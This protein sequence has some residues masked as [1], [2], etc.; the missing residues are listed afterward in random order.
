MT[1]L[2]WSF[3][4]PALLWGLL[5][6]PALWLLL[7]AMPPAPLR[8]RFPAVVLLLGLKDA[9]RVAD[10]T[11][12]WLILLRAAAI[13][14]A[15]IGF[16]G[17]TR[18]PIDTGA[19]TAPLLIV[20][21]ASWAKA[22]DWP[23]MRRA[24][25]DALDGALRAG[26]SAALVR[27]TD[28]PTPPQWQ[29]AD[30]LAQSLAAA[31]PAP[32]APSDLAAWAQTL[33]DQ[34]FD[35]LWLSDGLDYAGR[36]ELA[37]ALQS[38]GS[39]EVV[40][41]ARPVFGLLP[42]Q[43]EGGEIA[44]TALRLP[45]PL[46][47]EVVITAHGPSPSGADALLASVPARFAG[48]DTRARATLTLPPDLRN[49]ITRF[50]IAGQRSAG[51]VSLTDDAIKRRK[52]AIIS[53][54][55]AAEGLQ[56][57]SPTHYLT[58]ALAPSSDL[59]TGEIAT[60]LPAAPDTIIL[61]DVAKLTETETADLTAWVEDGGT[62]LRFAGPRLA[63]ATFTDA[64]NALLPVRLRAGGRASGGAMSWGEA[65]ALAPF[66]AASPFAGLV[67]DPDITVTSQV[68]AEPDPN[69]AQ[70]TLAALADGTPLITRR[71][72][73]AGQIVL[74]HVTANAEWSNLPLS[75]LFVQLLERL[76]VASR[77]APATEADV[78]GKTWQ[79]AR[80]TG[81]FGEGLDGSALGGVQGA[82][83]WARLN[84]GPSGD[85]PAG[86][87]ASDT[88]KIALNVLGADA[89]LT[90]FDW[91]AGVVLRGAD[92][93]PPAQLKGPLLTAAFVLLALD[94]IAAL[95][96][97]GK[98]GLA[99]RAR[100][101]SIAALAAALTLAPTPPAIAQ[102][103]PSASSQATD[104]AALRATRGVVLGHVITGDAQLDD[105]AQAGLN[106]LGM[107]L[108]ARTSIEPDPPV[109]VNIETDELSFFSFLYWP[110]SAAQPLPSANAT[111]KLNA[112]LR[113]G[114]MIMFDTRAGDI[115][116]GPE[117]QR[118][119]QITAGLDIP[120]LEPIPFDHVLTRAF[121]LVQTF[122]GRTEGPPVWVEA[123]PM[124]TAVAA[125][126]MPF[127]N[128][129]DGVTPVIIGSHDWA[130]AWAVDAFG[131]P[132]LPVGRGFAGE[133]QREYAYRFGVNVIM[134][135]LTGNYKS[136][137]VHV[138]ALLDRLSQ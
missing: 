59:L 91:P 33:E 50:E 2:G 35:T 76:A 120:P 111:A 5:A 114:G 85:V 80:L 55:A 112:F 126:G 98:L 116:G 15:I 131:S 10:R 94:I 117:D 109:G 68:L 52:V 121:Y 30:V 31:V 7:R 100:T 13:A 45:A 37:R 118:L 84:A 48:G 115:Q 77:N 90:G 69:L 104:F 56:L 11:P 110:I 96:V 41:P 23:H 119:Q 83:L 53:A 99:A 134:H 20:M 28:S 58:G 133:E 130:G 137:Q 27:L 107:V 43:F 8:R 19:S 125:E 51:A 87:Y 79:S 9:D 64:D 105:I 72:L 26:R 136:D 123:A 18:A 14:A 108:T 34:Q 24:G 128:L 135:V 62:L 93:A 74:F 122:P 101:A 29:S 88:R 21:D 97:G 89:T 65:K 75:G 95:F 1:V 12:W 3:L 36:S 92:L 113:T 32:R 67:I 103:T 49:R 42:A 57:L 82:D 40:L 60:V 138:P 86:L 102:A 39:V 38:A 132:L 54:A 106:G 22:H 73:G 44:L 81:A 17:P 124:D 25:L 129:N 16:A 61:A 46:P 71:K 47:A 63:S 70:N 4:A 127:R 66:D 6:L 78:L